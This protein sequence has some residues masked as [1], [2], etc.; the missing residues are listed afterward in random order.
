MFLSL[1]FAPPLIINPVGIDL[2]WGTIPPP[3]VVMDSLRLLSLPLRAADDVENVDTV[4]HAIRGFRVLLIGNHL[5]ADD[6]LSIVGTSAPSRC[7]V[8]R[9]PVPRARTRPNHPGSLLALASVSCFVMPSLPWA[10]LPFC[11]GGDLSL[12]GLSSGWQHG[13]TYIPATQKGPRA[14]CELFREPCYN[15]HPFG[16]VMAMSLS[17]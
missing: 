12:P 14:R 3:C 5:V 8:H 10:C 4:F 6:S 17:R 16:W 13:P 9:P 7:R 2:A 1:I 11:G 15:N